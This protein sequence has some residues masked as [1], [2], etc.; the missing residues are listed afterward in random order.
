M[1][2]YVHEPLTGLRRFLGAAFLLLLVG[3][4][5]WLLW[6]QP[7]PTGLVTLVVVVW[8]MM[9]SHRDRQS[10]HLIAERRTGESLCTFVRALPIRDLDTW[11]IRATYDGDR[12]YLSVT[13]NPNF[14]LR[15]SDG[16]VEDL[17]IDPDELD[18]LATEVAKR[19]GRTPEWCGTNPYSGR[20]VSVEDLVK[21]V[22]AQPLTG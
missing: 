10:I 21:L 1:P 19:A 6:N 16:L 7:I 22:C 2:P 12:D 15:P 18:D 13:G 11:V 20:V 9:S 8:S 17:K 3:G 4:Y 5:L 14:P